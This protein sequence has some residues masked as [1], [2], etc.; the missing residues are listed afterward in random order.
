MAIAKE[1]LAMEAHDMHTLILLDFNV[2]IA[3]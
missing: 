2:A 3:Q 1:P